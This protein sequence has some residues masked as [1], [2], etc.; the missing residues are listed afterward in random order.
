[1]GIFSD[2][3]FAILPILF[4]WS[5]NRPV[6]E[7]TLLTVLM[8]LGLTAAIAGAIR[9]YYMRTWKFGEEAV[10]ETVTLYMWYRVEEINLISSACA[11]FLKGAIE[12][13]LSQLGQPQFGFVPLSLQAI[14]SRRRGAAQEDSMREPSPEQQ[15]AG[16]TGQTAS[17]ISSGRS[18]DGSYGAKDTRRETIHA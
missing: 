12:S 10:K 7:R 16:N 15:L 2:L 11:P 14:R 1:V 8:G 17:M 3:I 9:L 4:I 6:L 18:A 13:L 5:L